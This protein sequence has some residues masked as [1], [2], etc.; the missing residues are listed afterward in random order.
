[1]SLGVTILVV[2]DE[3]NAREGLRQFLNGL[4]YDV[5]TA[6][7][8]KEALDLV[9]KARPEV[10]LADLKMPEM[11]GLDLLHE[12]KR[13]RPDTIVII[14]TAYG[15]VESAVQA[16]K[17]GAYYY[18]TKPINF[19]ELELILKKALNQK[20]LERE[21]ITLREELVRE[22]HETAEIIGRSATIR[23]LITLTKQVAQSDS[24]VL[25]QGESGTGKE[26]IAHLI[27]SESPRASYPFV[28][29]HVAAL[30]E[31]LLASELFGHEKGAFTGAI[32]RKIGRFERAN[33]GTLFLDEVSDIPE[34]MQ[35][36]LLRVLQSNEFERVGSVKTIRSDVRIV[37]A[38][39]KNLKE[40]VE[41]G[42]FRQDLFY[43]INVILLEVPPLRERREDIVL[44]AN[45]YLKYFSDKNRKKIDSLAPEA[46]SALSQYDWPGNVRELKNIM[47][48]VAVLSRSNTIALEQLPDDIRRKD[49]LENRQS[50]AA[51]VKNSATIQEMEQEM[52]RRTLIEANRNKSLAAKKLGI[53]RRTLYRKLAEYKISE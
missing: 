42:H 47:E 31:T 33:G 43:R 3:K 5:H 34:S 37:C 27:H 14:L 48:R 7:S 23:K 17:A 8:G 2:D 12:I 44:L 16:M 6:G 30:T 18:L 45:H 1:M 32:E 24:A 13:L 38:T 19:E 52:I 41:A 53:S 28:T 49:K 20:A 10:I 9:K 15:T 40:E 36:K 21:N 11:S 50:S 35:T 46:L 22:R 29:V 39:N 26:L 4:D 25:I 51:K